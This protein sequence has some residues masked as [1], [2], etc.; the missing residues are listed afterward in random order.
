MKPPN[1]RLL[2]AMSLVEARRELL[3]EAMAELEDALSA[4]APDPV[5]TDVAMCGRRIAAGGATV[6][7]V[8]PDR[9][10]GH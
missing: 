9:R 6:I 5:V 8:K 2:L 10:R 7:R 1:L 3:R 4:V